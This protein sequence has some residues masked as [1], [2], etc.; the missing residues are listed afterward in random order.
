MISTAMSLMF[1]AKAVESMQKTMKKKHA[2]DTKNGSKKAW[3]YGGKM[4]TA[5]GWKP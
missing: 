2:K 5:D 4:F 1:A 3:D